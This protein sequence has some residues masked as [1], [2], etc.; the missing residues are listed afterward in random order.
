[1]ADVFGLRAYGGISG[2][3]AFVIQAAIA[4][5]PLVVSLLV[6]AWG[7]YTPV[8]WALA[9]VVGLSALGIARVGGAAPDSRAAYSPI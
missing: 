6:V 5:G 8:F 1:V 4:A 9:A 3:I 2:T 7:G